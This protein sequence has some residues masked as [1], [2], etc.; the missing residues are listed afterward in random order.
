MS[1][2]MTTTNKIEE[3][4]CILSFDYGFS[5]WIELVGQKVWLVYGKRV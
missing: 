2:T 3:L 1:E 4:K 5:L